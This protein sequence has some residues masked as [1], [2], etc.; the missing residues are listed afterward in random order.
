MRKIITIVFL[1]NLAFNAT[2]QQLDLQTCLANVNKNY[3]LLKQKDIEKEINS[4]AI[5]RNNAQW[6]PQISVKGQA[7]YQSD[8]TSFNSGVAG[9]GMSPISK[10]QYKAYLDLNQTLYDGGMT[11]IKN[12]MQEL[13]MQVNT[14]A[15]EIEIRKIRLQTQ[16]FFFTALLAQENASVLETSKAEISER[17]KVQEAGLKFGTVRQSQIDILK[18]EL[19]KLDQNLIQNHYNKK[20]ALAVISLFSGLEINDNTDLE[21]PA[22]INAIENDFSKRLEFQN[23]E[24]QKN[25][26]NKKEQLSTNGTL[27]KLSL[28][29]Q[30]GYGRPGLNM[31]ND[32]FDTFYIV[33]ARVNWDISSF[34]TLNKDK[35]T[36]EYA[37][38]SIEVQKKVLTTNL[39]AQKLSL[40]A[41]V[42][43][44]TEMIEKDKQIV[45]LR[46]SISKV[47]AVELD[48]G[49]ATATTYLIEKNAE[50][51]AKQALKI[52]EVQLIAT[53]HEI[54]N[55]TG[56]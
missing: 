37:T 56:N 54:Q 5:T 51:Q 43:Q 13:S 40:D 8:V 55:L 47:A 12:D 50:T 17:I 42:S 18:V 38:E 4:I 30:G 19:L 24:I 3:P 14:N 39:Q 46:N 44:L 25:S 29:G 7:S 21:T 20:A 16:K 48:N 27:P 10:D 2:A 6:L 26:L 1:F 22:A 34:Y 53:Q 35:K 28:F 41:T 31:L 23:Y 32:D 11:N 9:F 33:G 52:H 49:I 36:T 45:L 15:V